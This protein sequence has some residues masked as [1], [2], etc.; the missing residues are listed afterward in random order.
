MPPDALQKFDKKLNKDS[1]KWEKEV[2]EL[3]SNKYRRDLGN[4]QQHRVYKWQ[5]MK[6][7]RT[8]NRHDSISS[9]ESNTLESSK[10]YSSKETNPRSRRYETRAT[11]M[12]RK[13]YGDSSNTSLKV[14]NL[15]NISLTR[16]QESLLCLGLS[17]SPVEGLDYFT[18]VKDISLFA[19]KLLF[20]KHF[21]KGDVN[22]IFTVQEELKA[23]RIL[24]SLLEEQEVSTATFPP[25]TP[26]P[27]L[28]LSPAV[29]IFVKL[30][31]DKLRELH[32]RRVHD[33]LSHEQRIAM[34]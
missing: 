3:K 12:K 31:V 1:Q 30:A 32:S 18:A 27:H 15:F 29:D 11:P 28:A 19:R 14:I 13:N 23:I 10:G 16:A 24:E 5:I 26:L 22:S 17:L 20:K 21:S 7:P 34:R 9:L 25:F 4:Y 6:P 2:Q 33:N 8:L